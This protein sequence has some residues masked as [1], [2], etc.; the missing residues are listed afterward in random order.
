MK[1]DVVI[2]IDVVVSV[3][4]LSSNSI[5]GIVPSALLAGLL[6]PVCTRRS[7]IGKQ[8]GR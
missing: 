2:V 1:I 5:A 8:A 4:E 6:L 3:P 7:G